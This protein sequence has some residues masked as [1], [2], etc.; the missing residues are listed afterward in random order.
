[1]AEDLAW[2]AARHPGRVGAGFAVGGLDRDFELADL[3]WKERHIRFRA[4]LPRVVDA[5]SGREEGGACADPAIAALAKQPMSLVIAAQGE[6]AV[7]L[8]AQLGVGLI[9]DSLQ[10]PESIGRLVKRYRAEG[11]R[12]PC[13][14]I[15]RVWLGPPPEG[16]VSTQVAFYRSYASAKAQSTWGAEELVTA[17]EPQALA[18]RLAETAEAARATALNLRFHAQ[19]VEAR[20]VRAQ[21]EAVGREVLPRLRQGW[22]G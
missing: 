17:S 20:A 13:I 8:G 10:P 11:G 3:A 16:E 9:F 1:V 7:A 4:A 12:G 18:D 19:G 15:R 22:S 2:L 6:R 14:L 5:L 21:I